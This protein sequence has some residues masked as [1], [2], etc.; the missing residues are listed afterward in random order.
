MNKEHKLHFKMVANLVGIE[1]VRRTETFLH[2]FMSFISSVT[3]QVWLV[4]YIFLF[5]MNLL[6]YKDKT[7]LTVMS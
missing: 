6:R 3:V 5:Q 2:L 1:M 4:P 7:S